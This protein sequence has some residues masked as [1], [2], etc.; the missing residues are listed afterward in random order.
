MYH[1]FS[2]TGPYDTN[3]N[4]SLT[5]AMDQAALPI[6]ASRM[7]SAG[8]GYTV[9]YGVG[10]VMC[11]VKKP[12]S[13]HRPNGVHDQHEQ[14]PGN[15]CFH[16]DRGRQHPGRSGQYDPQHD[17]RYEPRRN[18]TPG[19]GNAPT[20]TASGTVDLNG[21]GTFVTNPGMPPAM[22]SPVTVWSPQCVRE[23]AG[24]RHG[25]YLLHGRLGLRASAGTYTYAT[26]STGTA[27]T[28]PVCA[29][30]G[31]KACSCSNTLSAG[32]GNLLEGPDILTNDSRGNCNGAASQIVGTAGCTN[33][34]QCR[35]ELHGRRDRVF[36]AIC[37]I[38]SSTC[39]RGT[40]RSCR[41]PGTQNPACNEAGAS[42]GGDC[43]CEFHKSQSFTVADGS[44]QTIGVDEASFLYQKA[45]YIYSTA[46]SAWVTT[47]QKA[48][49]CSDLI[50]KGS[51]TGGLL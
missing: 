36:R 32:S 29:G 41:S 30:N 44:S 9:N 40:T 8:N 17:D 45:A 7:T 22:A 39:P 35:S 28:V 48:T 14:R 47:A 26:N 38:T 6:G 16:R 1:Y 49:S 19:A 15:L 20:V 18:S 10:A 5:D 11:M 34:S 24:L 4:G 25:Q 3:N 23:Y 21:N 12:G 2:T 42:G 33:P 46:H 43:F 27:S 50:T 31:N 13:V 37:S 51:A